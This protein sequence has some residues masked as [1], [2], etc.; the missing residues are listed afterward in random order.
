MVRLF[1]PILL[2]TAR[3]GR[4]TE[5]AARFVFEQAKKDGRFK[6]RFLDVR[7]FVMIPKTDGAVS[8][9]KSKEWKEIVTRADGLIIV[10]PE[11]NHGYPGELKLMLD[12]LYDEYNRKPAAICG[13]GAGMG[14]ARMVEALRMSL[15]EFQM[16]PIRTAVYFSNIKT[17]FDENGKIKD[18]SYGERLKK[19]FDELVWYAEA[20]KVA[21]EKK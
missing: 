15:V 10:S 2:G 1:I 4:R 12:Q 19:L 14:G 5:N 11:Y 7:D 9:E 20:L 16:V 13:T 6:T 3:E 21:R 18:E 8:E 17:L